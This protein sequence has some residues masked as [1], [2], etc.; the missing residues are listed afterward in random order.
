[1]S[2][3]SGRKSI[4]E[5]KKV[6]ILFNIASISKN[7]IITVYCEQQKAFVFFD[8]PFCRLRRYLMYEK[9]CFF[10]FSAGFRVGGI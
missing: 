1:M 7:N 2:A 4:A 3:A 5:E 8:I 9:N 6:R 10:Y